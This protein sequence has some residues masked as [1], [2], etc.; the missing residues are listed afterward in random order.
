[1]DEW[2]VFQGFLLTLCVLSENVSSDYILH[3]RL[4][5][6]ILYKFNVA[7]QTIGR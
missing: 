1:M 2:L 3:I 5:K 6:N 4:C 7:C